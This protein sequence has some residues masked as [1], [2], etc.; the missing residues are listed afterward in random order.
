MTLTPKYKPEQIVWALINNL[1]FELAVWEVEIKWRADMQ[2]I[3]YWFKTPD[4][5]KFAEEAQVF[6]TKQELIESL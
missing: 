6:N 3:I 1:V 4:D 5:L 2:K